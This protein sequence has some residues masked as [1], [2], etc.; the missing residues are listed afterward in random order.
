MSPVTQI[1]LSLRRLNRIR[2]VD[3]RNWSLVVEAGCILADVQRAADQ[4]DRFFPLSLGS[5]GT[6]QIGGNLSTN[7]GGTNVVRYGMMR[8]Q[9]LGLEV[10][11]PNGRVLSTLNALRKDNTGYDLE[12]AVRRRGG[13][14]RRDHGGEPQAL[15]ED[16]RDGHGVCGGA[17]HAGRRDAAQRAARSERRQRQSVR[18]DPAYRCRSHDEAHSRRGAIR[19]TGAYEWYVL[20]EL[21][22]SR[23]IDTLVARSGRRARRAPFRAGSFSTV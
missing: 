19:W 10:V 14:A 22:S 7:A 20:C 17:E 1:V 23:F 9:V 5:E 11:L 18:A 3:A 8:D 4:V 6:C 16:S 21:T 15:S 12:V 13:H 2:N